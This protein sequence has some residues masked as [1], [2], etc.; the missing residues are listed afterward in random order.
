ME[1]FAIYAPSADNTGESPSYNIK[2]HSSTA[3]LSS[4][5]SKN[6]N[7]RK[8][9]NFLV[10]PQDFVF[11]KKEDALKALKAN[12]DSRFKSFKSLEDALK[13]AKSGVNIIRQDSSCLIDTLSLL[14][15]TYISHKF[16]TWYRMSQNIYPKAND[17]NRTMIKKKSS[18]DDVC[19]LLLLVPQYAWYF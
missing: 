10:D 19:K 12:K 3:S 16:N 2:C 9:H 17:R 8:F 5:K 1:Y 18:R 13:F 7:L 4:L 6:N 11:V 14:K 15:C